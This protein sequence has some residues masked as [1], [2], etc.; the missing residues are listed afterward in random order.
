MVG[1]QYVQTSLGQLSS[2]AT[3]DAEDECLYDY[4]Y[5]SSYFLFRYFSF[6]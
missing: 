2:P 1:I 4:M 6:Q 5:R 3:C